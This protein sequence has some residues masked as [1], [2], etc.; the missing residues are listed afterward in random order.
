MLLQKILFCIFENE[1]YQNYRDCRTYENLLKHICIA[2]PQQPVKRVKRILDLTNG[3]TEIADLIKELEEM[4]KKGGTLK[5]GKK[6]TRHTFKSALYRCYHIHFAGY[7]TI[8]FYIFIH[9]QA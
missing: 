9:F 1:L 5:S 3:T 7:L 8:L 4:T 6:F 2:P